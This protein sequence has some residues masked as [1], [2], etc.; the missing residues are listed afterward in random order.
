MEQTRYDMIDGLRAYST[1]GI[2]LMH[3]RAN[4]NFQIQGF[5]FN[6][7]ISSFTNLVF[8][9]MI[10]SAFSMCCGYYDRMLS[11]HISIHKFYSRRFGKVLPF[12]GLLCLLDLVMGFSKEALYEFIADITLCFGLLPNANI[13]VIGV[14]WFLGVVFVF[15]MLFPFFCWLIS[16]KKKALLVFG[17]AAVLNIVCSVYFLDESHVVDGFSARSNIVY[18]AV[19]FVL[20]GL[21]YLYREQLCMLATR[22]RYCVLTEIVAVTV[23][24]YAISSSVWTMLILFGLVLVYSLREMG[25]DTALQNPFTHFIS[26]ISMEIYLSHMVMYRVIDKMHLNTILGKG[27]LSYIFTAATTI[28]AAVVFSVVCKKTLS[29]AEKKL[30]EVKGSRL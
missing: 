11:G 24:Y 5:V 26:D 30:R 3:I 9:F 10:I 1:I 14:G 7:M 15:Y 23:A 17:V 27:W 18:C 25:G 29:I 2:V 20:G 8:L 16:T 22:C 13:S 21:I 6:S 19:F 12:F 28:I 4:G